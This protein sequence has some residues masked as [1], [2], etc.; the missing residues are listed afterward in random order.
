MTSANYLVYV[1]S[2]LLVAGCT[3]TRPTPDHATA[4]PPSRAI[5]EIRVPLGLPELPLEFVE[6]TGMANSP[7]GD[8]QVALYKDV[9]G[10]KYSVEPQT[11]QVVEIDA[12]SVLS[13]IPP[14]RRPLAQ[15]D[16]SSIA[17]RRVETTTPDFDARAPSL[18][19][20][21]G[22]K[23]D[24]YFFTWTDGTQAA[25]HMRPFAQIGLHVT[26]ELFAYYNTLSLK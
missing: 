26:G 20:E 24:H 15:A 13:S 3:L 4:N 22:S 25:A 18:V 7:D 17:K 5:D 1:V 11:N 23:G 10:R 14:E 9:E 16:L 2:A 6:I 8:L 12:R 19:Y 21:E